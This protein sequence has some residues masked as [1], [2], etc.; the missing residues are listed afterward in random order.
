MKNGRKVTQLLSDGWRLRYDPEGI[1]FT[2]GW[3]LGLGDDAIATEIP[4]VSPQYALYTWYELT[5][6][7]MLSPG[8]D[9]RACLCFGGVPYYTEY[10]LNGEPIGCHTGRH[11][12]FYFDVTD[13]LGQTCRLTVMTA[14]PSVQKAYRGLTQS[15]VGV[16]FVSQARFQQTVRLVLRPAVSLDDVFVRSDPAT[17]TVTV[18]AT[19]TAHPAS[20]CALTVTVADRDSRYPCGGAQTVMNGDRVTLTVPLSS[21]RLWSPEHPSLYTVTLVLSD[22]THVTDVRTVTT[23]FRTLRVDEA[24]YFELNGKRLYLKMTHMA[25]TWPLSPETAKDLSGYRQMLIYLKSCGFNAVRQLASCPL[26]QLLDLCDEIGMLMYSEHPMAWH[27]KDCD[28]TAALFRMTVEAALRRDRNHPCF[29]MFGMQNETLVRKEG[30]SPTVQLYRA[31]RESLSYARDLAPDVVFFLQSARFDGNR[32]LGS[33]SNPGSYVWDGYMGD[34]SSDAPDTVV[35]RHIPN[36]FTPGMGDVH[37][38]P[39][40]PHGKKTKDTLASFDHMKRGVFFSEAGVGS[41]ADI[42]TAKLYLEQYGITPRSPE[43]KQIAEHCRLFRE[44]YRDYRLDRI[45]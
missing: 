6:V 7:P 8:T 5:F 2:E 13:R 10:W 31:V 12:E 11:D 38:Y 44:F 37:L 1:G 22:A 40:M 20:A 35:D 39:V 32:S 26:P 4:G 18:E 42:F 43:E 23:A 36:Y 29:L 30:A 9:E 28:E 34:E 16:T 14:N 45:S 19:L 25:N 33:V 3:H 41:L 24:G 21:V 27:K 15:Q 17:Q